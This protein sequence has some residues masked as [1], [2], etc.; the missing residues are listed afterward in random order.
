MRESQEILRQLEKRK[1]FGVKKNPGLGVNWFL[2][3]FLFLCNSEQFR[4][5]FQVSVSLSFQQGG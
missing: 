3:L 5:P 1:V 4:P 2:D